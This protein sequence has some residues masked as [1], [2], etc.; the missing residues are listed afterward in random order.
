MV[1][2]YFFL[3]LFVWF[4]LVVWRFFP[5]KNP[6]KL[7]NNSDTGGSVLLILLEMKMFSISPF[8]RM[9]M[10]LLVNSLVFKE[11]PSAPVLHKIVLETAAVLRQTPFK[12]L[13]T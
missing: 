6:T 10:L 3:F 13:F 4:G 8:T 9:L 7:S 5:K 11:L 2:A 1:L 12:F